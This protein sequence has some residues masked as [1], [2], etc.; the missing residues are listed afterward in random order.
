MPAAAAYASTAWVDVRIG[1]A[2]GSEGEE[3]PYST[4][5][6][7]ILCMVASLA[8]GVARLARGRCHFRLG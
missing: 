4:S 8:A 3:M 2:V 1:L 6:P 7:M 5:V